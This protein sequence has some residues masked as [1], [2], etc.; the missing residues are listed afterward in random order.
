[1]G[2]IEEYNLVIYP[3]Y[4]Y[5]TLNCEQNY[6]NME[7]DKI[8]SII[9]RHYFNKPSLGADGICSLI[10]DKINQEWHL[11]SLKKSIQQKRVSS[12]QV[13]TIRRAFRRIKDRNQYFIRIPFSV[14][15]ILFFILNLLHSIPVSELNDDEKKFINFL[16][17]G[18]EI[19]KCL[20][21]YH[22]GIFLNK[23]STIMLSIADEEL[24]DKYQR[25]YANLTYTSSVVNKTFGEI[26]WAELAQYIIR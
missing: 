2:M 5:V 6:F 14:V 8:L 15:P 9:G 19:R 24:R 17:N 10:K 23:Y 21:D 20:Y 25:L 12:N 18:N 4:R 22:T 7:F 1:M 13:K 16:S 3:S 26:N 11:N